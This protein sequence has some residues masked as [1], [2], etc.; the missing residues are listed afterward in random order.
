MGVETLFGFG[1]ICEL[2]YYM[3]VEAYMGIEALHRGL[4]FYMKVEVL[5]G[6]EAL[7]EG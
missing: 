5:H 6:V 3:G 1:P 2:R 7:Y 4:R